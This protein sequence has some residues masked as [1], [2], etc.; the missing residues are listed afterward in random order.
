M[1]RYF[2]SI[3]IPS[4]NRC[5]FSFSYKE[6]CYLNQ[7]K[8]P[9]YLKLSIGN[10]YHNYFGKNGNSQTLLFLF[11]FFIVNVH[12]VSLFNQEHYVEI[13]IKLV[14]LL[15]TKWLSNKSN[16]FIGLV[17]AFSY[18]CMKHKSTWWRVFELCY[19]D[20]IWSKFCLYLI[21][22]SKYVFSTLHSRLKWTLLIL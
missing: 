12:V 5:I 17:E 6:C 16:L 21:C 8:K 11:C 14:Q 19:W 20:A 1:N 9:T 22:K 2:S 13:L 7:Y 15:L 18:V 4:L 3:Q 10:L